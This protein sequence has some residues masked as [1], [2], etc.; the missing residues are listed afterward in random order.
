MSIGM[1]SNIRKKISSYIIV[2]ATIG[3]T[4]CTNDLLP[5][6]HIE[7]VSIY[8]EP[9]TN[10]NSAIAV[11][12]VM[13]YD[14]ELV[15]LIG[16]MSAAKYFTSSKE[17]LLDNPTL[18]DIWHWELVPGQIVQ[19]FA[20]PQ[21]NGDAYAAYVFANYLTPG[22]H[23]IKVAPNGKVKILLMQNDLKNLVVY[24][25]QDLRLGTTM[26]D[27]PVMHTGPYDID[28]ADCLIKLGPIKE[29]TQPCKRVTSTSM[30]F[31]KEEDMPLPPTLCSL[32]K[33]PI[34]IVMRPLA[35]PVAI[36]PKPCLVAPPLYLN[37]VKKCQK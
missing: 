28:D 9:D 1:I 33:Q 36:A 23:R 8:T 22:S 7:T 4:S 20:P 14:Q 37:K 5:E 17:L 34:P 26:S 31:D 25:T 21:E 10:Q 16:Q 13:I 3:L 2:L 19:D 35:P 29:L 32:P 15:K 18:L 6:L 27:V 11:D 12:L 24:D 30:Q